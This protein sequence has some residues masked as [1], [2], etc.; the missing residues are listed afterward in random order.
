MELGISSSQLGKVITYEEVSP[1]TDEGAELLGITPG[2]PVVGACSDGGL[3]QV[4]AG[5]TASGIMTFSVGTSGAIRLSTEE[6]VLPEDPGTWCYLSPAGYL[7]G[8]ATSGCCNC[9]DWAKDRLF[10]K[11]E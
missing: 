5:A 11:E 10:G 6:P 2:I 1:L 8:A 4:G 3:N 7:S 9:V